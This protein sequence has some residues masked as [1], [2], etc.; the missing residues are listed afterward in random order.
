MPL[1][2]HPEIW[3]DDTDERFREGRPYPAVPVDCPECGASRDSG[4][5]RCGGDQ[6]TSDDLDDDELDG[7]PSRSSCDDDDD[8]DDDGPYDPDTERYERCE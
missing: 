6:L 7:R 3:D 5:V 8:D 4:C 1:P 2:E